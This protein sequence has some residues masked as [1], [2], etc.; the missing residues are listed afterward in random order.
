MTTT[1]LIRNLYHTLYNIGAARTTAGLALAALLAVTVASCA[2]MGQPDGGWF[3]DTPPRIVSSSPGDKATDVK[4][5]KV[6]INF[7]EYIKLEDATNK[8]VV[9]PPQLEMPEIK[10]AGKKIVVELKDTLKENTT[11]TIDFSDAITD[12]NEGNPMG[13]YT[14]SFATG[15]HIDTLEVS[16]CVLDA[17]N[18]EPVKGILVGLHQNLSDTAFTT[19]P[20][21]RVARTD[22]SGR[23]TIKG[24]AP[25][26]YRAYALQDADGDYIFSQKSEM[27]A[28][29]H[30]TFEPSCGPDTRQDTIWRDELRIDTIV[31][32]PFTHFYPD[33]FILRAFT[34]PQ[35]DRYLL[36]TERTDERKFTL[37][38]TYGSDRLPEIRGLNFN[39][40][41][42]FITE[43]SEKRDTISYWLRDTALVN[44]DTLRMEVTYL[45]TD[46]TGALVSATDT[47]DILAKT[48]YEKRMKEKEKELEKWQ[49]T[50]EKAKKKGEPYDSVMPQK[51]L[52]PM[53]NIP[54][55]MDPD[56]NVVIE[57]PTPL[58][59]FDTAAVHLYA[60]YDTLWYRADCELDTIA[61]QQ[62]KY[63]FRAEWQP[64]VEYSIEID[65]AACEDIYGLVSGPI[66]RGLKVRTLD[67]YS[68]LTVNLSGIADTAAVVVQML[69]G[70]GKM[71]K[72]AAATARSVDFYYVT[73]GRYFLSA[74]IDRNHNGKW[75]TGDYR[76]DIQ[77]EEVY[78]NPKEI[79]CKAKWD[80][81][82]EWNLTALP[83]DRQK[84]ASI[85]KQKPDKEKKLR[86]RNA[87][88]A[89]DKG[90]TY[91]PKR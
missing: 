74:F 83:L 9:S 10:S 58:A 5:R 79:E 40:D 16:G 64:G 15:D 48:S 52:E 17:S 57:M 49:K 39:A 28:F 14:Y 69:N 18:L 29:S 85:T 82:H 35:T 67:E 80:I 51:H 90:V 87:E 55:M 38:F 77:P 42:A 84:P 7:D 43:P 60:K 68:S 30:E 22:G 81:T 25:G 61:G 34:E 73:P 41:N 6:T 78:Y 44:Q 59:R 56:K 8:V 2:R 24:V 65:S 3:D 71:V 91:E 19:Q 46:T 50:I 37:Y 20:L 53:V 76:A 27:V 75:D 89:K 47:M 33:N 72:E 54:S 45:R 26:T 1:S 66:K 62:R 23:F 32:V 88:R 31:R 13:K 36:K 63:L 12:N 11:Y 21:V 86:N 4:Q 70:S